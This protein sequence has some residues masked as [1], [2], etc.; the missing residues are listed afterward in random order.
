MSE[1]AGMG[2]EAGTRRRVRQ[3][4][5]VS[6]RAGAKS[7][8]VRVDRRVAH[9]RYTKFIARRS[10]FMAHDETDQCGIGDVVEI[11]SCRPLSASKRWRVSRIVKKAAGV[12]EV[13]VGES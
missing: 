12:A 13:E 4:G 1:Q 7:V 6:S 5:T 2:V 9:P 11:V 10:K 8:V 3:L